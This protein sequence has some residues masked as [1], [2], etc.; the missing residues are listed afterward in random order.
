MKVKCGCFPWWS[1]GQHMF[2]DSL[3]NQLLTFPTWQE[4]LCKEETE[5]QED[6][7]PF[8]HL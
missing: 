5:R 1:S 8:S 6:H 4:V 7:F 2:Q 3:A